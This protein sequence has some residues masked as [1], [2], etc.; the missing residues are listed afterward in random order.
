MA[1]AGVRAERAPVELGATVTVERERM[2]LATG[3]ALAAID[4]ARENPGLAAMREQAAV[5]ARA[6]ARIAAH[7]G[8]LILA[9]GER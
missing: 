1:A 4:F 3:R 7:Y 9:G 2:L 5:M 6:E 8:A